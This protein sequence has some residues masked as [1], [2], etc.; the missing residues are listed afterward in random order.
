LASTSALH[1]GKE[2]HTITALRDIIVVLDGSASSE[3]RLAIAIALAQQ[4]NAY[5][6]GLSA[7]ALLM[8]ARPVV[9]PRSYPETDML[10][11]PLIAEFG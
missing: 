1:R 6:T 10:P 7:L 11:A 5:L 3:T 2:C 4:H 9:H 8:P